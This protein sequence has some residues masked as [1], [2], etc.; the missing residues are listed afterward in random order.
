[1]VN[2]YI[3]ADPIDELEKVI[4][5][6]NA[7][8]ILDV[9]SIKEEIGLDWSKPGNRF[10]LNEIITEKIKDRTKF[11]RTKGIIYVNTELTENVISALKRK[12]LKEEINKIVLIDDGEFPKLDFMYPYVD[13]IFFYQKFRKVKIL[14]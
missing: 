8:Y 12:F 2:L 14:D 3:S 5:N 9:Q 10:L 11:K 13:E 1:M 4:A 7:Y 6:V